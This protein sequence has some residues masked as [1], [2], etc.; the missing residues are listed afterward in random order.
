MERA[1]AADPEPV[2]AEPPAMP[3]PAPLGLTL[4]EVTFLHWQVQPA[5]VRPLLPRRTEPDV[6]GDRTY[7]GLVAFRMRSYGEFLE[8][9]V[10]IYSVDSNGRRG[11]VF[12]SMECD[13]LPWVLAAR[14]GRLPYAWSRMHLAG[15]V[16]TRTY[17]SA[18]RR[19]GRSGVGSR[20]RVRIGT[21]VDG[22]E[23]EHFLTARWR[24]HLDV[25][26]RTATVPLWH[27]RWPLHSAE[28]LDFDDHLIAATGL[29]SPTTAPS[30][31]LYAPVARGRLGLVQPV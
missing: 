2:T 8:T 9:N 31:V 13:R 29:P 30:S 11:I 23:L 28:L 15:D 7:V 5:Q 27:E 21:P 1:N 20:I 14:A 12:L 3:C 17:T 6:I 19:P 26:G 22:T 16:D 24:L 18:R 4:T 25:A 10:R